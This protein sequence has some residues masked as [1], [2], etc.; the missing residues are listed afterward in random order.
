MSK[1]TVIPQKVLADIMKVQQSGLTNMFDV[2]A[3][4]MLVDEWETED[5]IL[6]NKQAYLNGISHGFEAE[7]VEENDD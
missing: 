2:P 6:E 4:C 1:P 3:V 5:W 7:Q